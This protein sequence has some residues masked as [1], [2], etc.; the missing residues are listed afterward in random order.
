MPLV[1]VA[2]GA[3]LGQSTPPPGAAG[4]VTEIEQAY[5]D[6][7]DAS[8]AVS[9]IDS[10][11]L[12]YPDRSYGGKS[13][14]AWAQLYAARRR[15]LLGS[16]DGVPARAL[17][18]E[19][20]RAVEV[21]RAAVAESS[22]TADSLAPVG[23]CSD[24]QR[25]DL[26]LQPLQQALYA[27]FAELGNNLQFEGSRVTRVAAFELLTR[28]E[29]PRRRRALFMA[30]LPL[31]QS[32]NGRDEAQSSYS[33]MMRMAAAEAKQN[34]S[35]VDAAARTL[36]ASTADVERWLEQI[37][38]TWRQVGGGAAV[39]PWDYRFVGGAA[40]RELGAAIPRAALTTLTQRYYRDLGLDLANPA[41][42]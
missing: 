14:E 3:A 20:A 11:P 34:G 1:L 35:A 38:E 13:R 15:E 28:M 2:R 23:H 19:D 17:S 6:F 37:L 31:W 7:N 18:A 29:Q 42:I 9:L 16:L 26:Q 12:S 22:A 21:M 10:D 27:C 32:L 4:A 24:A 39:E 41:V 25:Q 30:F 8:G 36:G 33:R 40:E 5:A